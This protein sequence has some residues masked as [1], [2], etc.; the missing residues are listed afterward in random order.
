MKDPYHCELEVGTS[1][2]MGNFNFP[3]Q[4]LD[5]SKQIWLLYILCKNY[6][7]LKC[8]F[9]LDTSGVF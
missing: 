6:I 4:W 3:S 1:W 7:C 5:S 8:G 2:I 9:D